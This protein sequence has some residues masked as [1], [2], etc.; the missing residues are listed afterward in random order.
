MLGGL[1]KLH[2]HRSIED[3]GATTVPISCRLGIGG[4]TIICTTA[5][6]DCT[7]VKMKNLICFYL[8]CLRTLNQGGVG[9]L[10]GGVRT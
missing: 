8:I 4:M 1:H 3:V 9:L 7:V 5:T 6:C 2:P 10:T